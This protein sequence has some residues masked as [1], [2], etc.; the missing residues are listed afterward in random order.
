MTIAYIVF[1]FAF[2]LPNIYVVPPLLLYAIVF[3]VFFHRY[4]RALWLAFDCFLDQTD[5]VES[6]LAARPT[7]TPEPSLPDEP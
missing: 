3:P 1:H 7:E 2:A 5:L 6:E 4:A